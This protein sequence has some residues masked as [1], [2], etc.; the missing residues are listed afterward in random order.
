MEPPRIHAD[1][2]T[3]LSH[4]AADDEVERFDLL[5]VRLP[6]V[7]RFQRLHHRRAAD[8]DATNGYALLESERLRSEA[9]RSTHDREPC[10]RDPTAIVALRIGWIEQMPETMFGVA[11]FLVID[12]LAEQRRF[13]VSITEEK[14]VSLGG[15]R[16]A[17]QLALP[18]G[19]RIQLSSSILRTE[20]GIAARS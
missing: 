20:P 3:K 12:A 17:P 2:M 1:R 13:A 10:L 4:M 18:P 14:R 9:Q 16:Q 7:Q 15:N 6:S 5:R 11:V 8:R 19:L